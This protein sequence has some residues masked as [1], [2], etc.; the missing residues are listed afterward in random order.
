MKQGKT[1]VLLLLAVLLV[2]CFGCDVIT[3][4]AVYEPPEAANKLPPLP[5]L[6]PERWSDKLADADLV[7]LGTITALHDT[8][9]P[10]E[11]LAFTTAD[12][13]V[14]QVLKGTPDITE[15]TFRAAID[16]PGENL[17]PGAAREWPYGVSDRLLISLYKEPGNLYTKGELYWGESPKVEVPPVSYRAGNYEYTIDGAEN[18]MGLVIRVMQE[19]R[20]PV[21]MENP[22]SFNPKRELLLD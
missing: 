4:T 17:W 9:L 2:S 5:E 21:A 16:F 10:E 3:G 12:F 20:I 18:W 13:T 14:E 7:V 19:Y 22:P 6:P 11:K 1:F 8:I 15:V